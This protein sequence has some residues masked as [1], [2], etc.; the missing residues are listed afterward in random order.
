M[1]AT[2]DLR[3][4]NETAIKK[5]FAGHL[6]TDNRHQMKWRDNEDNNDRVE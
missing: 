5:A 6:V 2:P 1:L 3:A 4:C